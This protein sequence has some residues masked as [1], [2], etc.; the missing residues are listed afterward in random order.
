[1]L[2]LLSVS[3]QAA[4]PPLQGK[5]SPAWARL[6]QH[7]Q[8]LTRQAEIR[9]V[10]I[11]H[12]G[13][14]HTAG[15]AF[16]GRLRELFQQ[17]FPDSGPGFI[18]PGALHAHDTGPYP[19]R[20][21]DGWISERERQPASADSG[22]LGG[23]VAY[24]QRPYQLLSYEPFHRARNARLTLYT[25]PEDSGR[26]SRFKLYLDQNEI[27]AVSR[28]AS[29]QIRY[30]LPAGNGRLDVLSL[31][32]GA[33]PRLRGLSLLYD[34]RGV[35]YCALGVNGATFSILREWA[36]VTTRMEMADYQPDLLIL[37]FGTNDV[38]ASGFSREAFMAT[39][40]QTEAWVRE[41][42][43]EAA[44][45]LILPPGMPRQAPRIQ[46][47]LSLLRAQLQSNASK[48]GWLIWDWQRALNDDSPAGVRPT[49]HHVPD[50]IHLTTAGYTQ[51]ASWLFSALSA[52]F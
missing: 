40:R 6:Q 46:E 16:S 44:V 5:T 30:A 35:S 36:G 19:L 10:R 4:P 20:Q 22:A 31:H 12:L 52:F 38:L 21:S 14:S 2:G 18:P 34:T 7:F 50:G 25:D 48:N 15:R 9:P 41:Y 49:S 26:P 28:S 23:F 33:L 3:A 51:S 17:R 45:L 39:L 29:G 32:G 42:A 1:M 11:L 47:N 8:A 24:S 27:K 43:G 13:D 37:E